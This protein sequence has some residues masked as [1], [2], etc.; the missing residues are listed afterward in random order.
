[1]NRGAILVN[2]E[3]NTNF[4][5]I[6]L[7]ITEK[8][9]RRKKSMVRLG[10]VSL[11][12]LLLAG[13]GGGASS[14]P[15]PQPQQA[16]VPSDFTVIGNTYTSTGGGITTLSQGDSTADLIVTSAGGDDT[17]TTGTGSDTIATGAGDDTIVA[18]GGD[19]VI[20]AGDGS[21]TVEGGDGNDTIVLVG[22]TTEGQYSASSIT[23]SAGGAD[24]SGILSES[25]LNN[26]TVSEVGAGEVIDGGA[27]NDSLV[28]YGTAYINQATLLNLDEMWVNSEVILTGEQF[29]MFGAFK[30]DGASVLRV[31]SDDL[32]AVTAETDDTPGG[33]RGHGNN[34]DGQ[35]D[36]N[37]GQGKGGPNFRDKDG[38]DEDEAGGGTTAD[39]GT[40]TDGTTT[41]IEP[42][43]VNI[44]SIYMEAIGTLSLEGTIT[45]VA[46]DMHDF[47]GVTNIN[48]DGA[49]NIILGAVLD[50][51]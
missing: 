13:C 14:A 46:D 26:N 8:E 43:I 34:T 49:T 15:A 42:T 24:M 12:A 37:P 27:G 9:K 50:N 10:G 32:E 23:N 4:K 47:A 21:D 51:A 1:M 18:G 2:I 19:D 17:I 7:S 22:T 16:E 25:D 36:N 31:R 38:V 45:L 40:T 11:N 39:G 29:A 30:G 6:I 28:I 3:A 20:H 5:S 48:G 33:N 44:S 41:I 35:D